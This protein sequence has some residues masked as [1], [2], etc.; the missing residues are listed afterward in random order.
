MVN[1]VI[2]YTVEKATADF[3]DVNKK[4]LSIINLIFSRRININKFY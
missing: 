4:C 3:L 2:K 1:Y